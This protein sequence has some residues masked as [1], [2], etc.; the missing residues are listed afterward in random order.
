ML[1]MLMGR[2]PADK[3]AAEAL[4]AEKAAAEER[5]RVNAEAA[6]NAELMRQQEAAATAAAGGEQQGAG[7]LGSDCDSDD[8]NYFSD[9][10]N[11][12]KGGSRAA[13]FR[14]VAKQMRHPSR[15]R[16][17]CTPA[18]MPRTQALSNAAFARALEVVEKGLQAGGKG[19]PGARGRTLRDLLTSD[20]ERL[21]EEVM[22]RN[23]VPLLIG[24]LWLDQSPGLQMD[25]LW[26]LTNIAAGR[27]EHAQV[28]MKHG[29]V[30]A[31][32]HL[33][34]SPNRE[35]VEQSLWV[36]G[37]VAGEG[38][39]A[40]DA[41][42]AAG[43]LTPLVRCLDANAPHLSLCRIGSWVL[44][45]LF[46]GQPRP[47]VDVAAVLPT[48]SRLLRSADGEVLSHT[49]W[50][51]SHLCDGP[52]VHIKAVV[53]AEICQRLV[54]L[55]LHRSWRVTKPALRTIGNIVCAEDEVDY[56][57]YIMD[58][59]AVP[60]LR[61]LITHSTR[62]VQKEACWTLSNIAAG[63]IDQIQTV[64]DSGALPPLVQ[65]ATSPQTDAEVRSEAYWVILNATSC[66]S[67]RQIEY[68]VNIEYLVK[69]GCVPILGELLGESSMVMMALEGLERVLQVGDAKA[70][71]QS[72]DGV[73]PYAH[74]LSPERIEA[75][76][77]HK[78]GAIARR[79]S[80]I[81]KLYFVS[82][83][84]CC[85][86][87]SRHSPHARFCEEC[88]CHV[89]RG[90]DCTIFHLSYQEQLWQTLEGKEKGAQQARNAARKCKKAKRKL[91][92]RERKLGADG[93]SNAGT[94]S[95]KTRDQSSSGGGTSDEEGGD[96]APLEE[97]PGPLMLTPNSASASK[98]VEVE[99]G[100]GE[101]EGGWLRQRGKLSEKTKCDGSNGSSAQ[102][103]TSAQQ[104]RHAAQA[105][106]PIV[107]SSTAAG[108]GAVGGGTVAAVKPPPLRRFDEDPENGW[109]VVGQDRQAR[110][111]SAGSASSG[112]AATAAATAGPS[113]GRTRQRQTQTAHART[114]A[115]AAA[116]AKKPATASA[117]A[118]APPQQQRST[119][120]APQQQP[121][122]AAGPLGAWGTP[123]VPNGHAAAAPAP[124]VVT[125]PP[126]PLPVKAP[127]AAPV[128]AAAA[129]AVAVAP[130]AAEPAFAELSADGLSGNDKLV[131]FLQETG[132]ILMLAE[133]L[134]QE[135]SA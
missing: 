115:A 3:A 85:R 101:G 59:G 113:Y 23:W 121:Q 134:D 26:A 80:R 88:Q 130:P 39:T 125:P 111:H 68:L 30:P 66:G 103:N 38:T 99:E 61:Q 21:I 50:A 43:T 48:L 12:G 36:L 65:L 90:C 118:A 89:C 51:L 76:E 122:A 78:T 69:Q 47:Q 83:A 108:T 56:T 129:A 52:S 98:A 5:A 60:C 124:A 67:D 37:N 58:A 6:R 33:L 11:W 109:K 29:S 102:S 106:A 31:L 28:L 105:A 15:K 46:D 119:A 57:Q 132:S 14:T 42:L 93:G 92:A 107:K 8:G 133:L 135:D 117:P 16:P 24:W 110:S 13:V 116:A 44:S 71:R 79:A 49:C 17:M 7:G 131:T 72:S 81:W 22:D 82:C 87:F 112:A 55:L 53:D 2:K 127:A 86:S 77:S 84:I 20:R 4:A 1:A 19:G 54:D 62:E 96:T 128:V 94:P 27:A 9:E 95:K 100:E 63:T 18:A 45:N 73:N 75:L 74:L 70:R 64:L 126:P 35:V 104:S 41:V 34:S 10:N 32:V 91:K 97:P 123:L 25:A 120:K 40:R 114:A